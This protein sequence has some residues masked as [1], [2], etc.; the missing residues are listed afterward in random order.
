M[1][2]NIDIE[3]WKKGIPQRELEQK[4]RE[5]E[6][7]YPKREKMTPQARENNQTR[8]FLED[9]FYELHKKQLAEL[10]A[11]KAAASGLLGFRE[12]NQGIIPSMNSYSDGSNAG[13]TPL[14]TSPTLGEGGDRAYSGGGLEGTYSG[15]GLDSA[16]TGLEASALTP[17]SYGATGGNGGQQVAGGYGN[18]YAA[19][20]VQPVAAAEDL[21]NKGRAAIYGSLAEKGNF[22]A[23]N[24]ENQLSLTKHALDTYDKLSY[25]PQYINSLLSEQK[26]AETVCFPGKPFCSPSMAYRNDE[27]LRNARDFQQNYDALQQVGS[28]KQNLF[29]EYEQQR[30]ELRQKKQQQDAYNSKLWDEYLHSIPQYGA[31][32]LYHGGKA[33]STPR[34]LVTTVL[35]TGGYGDAA[36]TFNSAVDALQSL[37][38]LSGSLNRGDIRL[39]DFAN[40]RDIEQGENVSDRFVDAVIFPGYKP[41]DE[42]FK[43]GGELVTDT[44]LSLDK[45]PLAEQCVGKFENVPD[46]VR[47]PAGKFSKFSQKYVEPVD[48]S[49]PTRYRAAGSVA[50]GL[51]GVAAL[52]V[53][54]GGKYVAAN[55][56][57]NRQQDEIRQ[58]QEQIGDDYNQAVLRERE[59]KRRLSENMNKL[60]GNREDI[61]I[62]RY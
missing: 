5:Y 38:V 62:R 22:N 28:E 60:N 24:F 16:N 10:L 58:Q 20:Y 30:Y 55:N 11:E 29:G 39:K 45:N 27:F 35:E 43:L 54:T 21:F 25:N 4:I 47:K 50:G 52:T 46:F 31:Y 17:A 57:F 3:E 6:E 56:T 42:A 18:N 44:L 49:L 36:N 13:F 1:S 51:G 61:I 34:N 14:P 9:R 33:V 59:I 15:R 26:N 32:G 53:G 41:K 12:G 40:L 2:L 19:D 23:Q 37:N 48:Q 7:A 8:F